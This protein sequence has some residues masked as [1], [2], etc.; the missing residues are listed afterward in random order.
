MTAEALLE[1]MKKYFAG[2]MAPAA[3][4][5]FG[6]LSPREYLKESLDVV[7]FVVFLEEELEREIDLQQ[8]GQALFQMNFGALAAEIAGM[9]AAEG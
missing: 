9:L 4:E 7:D 8:V 5:Q 3:L 1:T 6:E 2:K